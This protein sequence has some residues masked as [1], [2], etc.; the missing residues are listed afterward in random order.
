MN[1]SQ[2]DITKILKNIILLSHLLSHSVELPY[3]SVRN[4]N[5][6]SFQLDTSNSVIKTD[7]LIHDLGF[8]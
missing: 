7:D 2:R 4:E 5:H 8:R 3:V 6:F 1:V